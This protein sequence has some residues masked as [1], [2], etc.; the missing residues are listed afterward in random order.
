MSTLVIIMNKHFWRL[1]TKSHRN[2]HF[3][4]FLTATKHHRLSPY[5]HIKWR[6]NWMNIKHNWAPI[7]NHFFKTLSQILNFNIFMFVRE[8]ILCGYALRF[9]RNVSRT[10]ATNGLKKKMKKKTNRKLLS[11]HFFAYTSTFLP[12]WNRSDD[13]RIVDY[14]IIS[15]K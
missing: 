6:K 4:A 5:P 8:Q 13:L 15:G 11:L 2:F 14:P 9:S 12:S 3:L 10:I 7:Q 1:F